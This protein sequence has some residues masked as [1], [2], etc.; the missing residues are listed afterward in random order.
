LGLGGGGSSQATRRTWFTVNIPSGDG[1]ARKVV[2]AAPA[3]AVGV[4][5]PLS[6]GNFTNGG[7]PGGGGSSQA[8]VLQRKLY[9]R[10]R[11]RRR[12]TI[13]NPEQTIIGTPLENQNKPS[14]GTH[15]GDEISQKSCHWGV[16]LVMVGVEQHTFRTTVM[17]CVGGCD[18]ICIFKKTIIGDTHWPRN[19]KKSYHW[20]VG[21]ATLGI[22]QH[23]FRTTVM[24]CVVGCDPIGNFQKTIIG[25]T[26]WR[27][28]VRKNCHWEVGV[29]TIGVE[30]H[31][32][33]TT[34]FVCVCGCGAIGAGRR[35]FVASNPPDLFHRKLSV[36]RRMTD[37]DR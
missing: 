26:H 21:L 23:T 9:E 19:F 2:R 11:P 3:A 6:S 37:N 31:T 16:G 20:R 1:S 27:P 12:H 25:D 24:G 17:G 13:G 7:G 34:V 28:N 10:R 18:P 8:T 29:A 5:Q 14:L 36:R 35:R 30:Q 22:E 15:M 33:R 4:K 32:F